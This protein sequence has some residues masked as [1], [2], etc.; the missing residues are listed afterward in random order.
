MTCV[1]VGDVRLFLED[2]SVGGFKGVVLLHPVEFVRVVASHQ[3]DVVILVVERTLV[4]HH[5]ASHGHLL[6]SKALGLVPHPN[7]NSP[8][9][10]SCL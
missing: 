1:V 6:I 10:L 9:W 5:V 3:Y 2:L 8:I 4:H 7:D